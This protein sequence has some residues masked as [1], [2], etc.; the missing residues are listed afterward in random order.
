M[1]REI[2]SIAQKKLLTRSTKFTEIHL[3][4]LTGNPIMYA[5]IFEGKNLNISIEGRID[6]TVKSNENTSDH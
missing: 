4:V 2:W 3:T 5:L 1:F 6:I